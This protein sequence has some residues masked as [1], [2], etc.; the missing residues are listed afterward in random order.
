MVY[1]VRHKEVPASNASG[2]PRAINRD[3]VD[4]MDTVGQFG[5]VNVE[6]SHGAAAVHQTRE[7]RKS[8]AL[9]P[10]HRCGP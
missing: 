9:Q 4:V 1:L 2:M 7:E 8:D 3:P 6:K 10:G 5:R